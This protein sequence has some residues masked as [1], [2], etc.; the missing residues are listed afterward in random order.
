[1]NEGKIPVRYAKAFYLAAER[2]G[3]IEAVTADIRQLEELC[4]NSA[5][6]MLFLQSTVIRKSRKSALLIQLFKSHFQPLTLRFL[7]LLT[8]NRRESKL[9]LICID[10]LDIIMERQGISPVTLTTASALSPEV[11]ENIRRF[12]EIKTGKTIELT[13][14]IRPEIVGGLIIRA[15]DLQYDGSIS[16]QLKKLKELLLNKELSEVK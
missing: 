16:N 2:S 11:R 3:A 10:F 1:M 9:L 12:L 7:L 6:F 15:G 8:E 5:D 4:R 14:K 13:E